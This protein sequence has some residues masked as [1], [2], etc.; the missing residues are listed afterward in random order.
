MN[1]ESSVR[2]VNVTKQFPVPEKGQADVRAVE[3]I[4]LDIREGEFF[5]LLGPSG[6]GKTTT[7]RL[8]AGF[9]TPDSGMVIIGGQVANE[10]APY[11]RPVNTVFQNYA[12]FPHLTVEQNVAFGL[13]VKR[14]PVPEQEQRVNEALELV[15]MGAYG[16]RRPSQLSGG[17]QQRV[18]LARALVNRPAVLL[19]DEPLGALDLRLRK[20]MQYEL[21][22]LQVEV[23]ITFI[24]VTHDQEEA[25]TMSD[26]IAVMNQGEVLQIGSP[27]EI[28]DQPVDRF[29]AS[30]IGDT[31][32]LNAQVVSVKNGHVRLQMGGGEVELPRNGREVT[33]GQGVTV[34]IRPEKLRILRSD[35]KPKRGI[36]LH[37]QIR[38]TIFAGPDTRHLV[39]LENGERLVVLIRSKDVAGKQHFEPGDAVEVSCDSSGPRLLLQ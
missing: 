22:R 16:R 25:L 37:G 28:Y 9:E 17:Q 32:L 39:N 36:Q 30:F 29:V 10:L 2:L 33:A 5:T 3:D 14:I 13:K 6:C 27:S 34:A 26:R 15:Q 20:D 8:I 35:G 38:E 19:L 7:L 1:A 21:K 31:N 24:Y 4:S 23:G 12:L 18:A 11:Q